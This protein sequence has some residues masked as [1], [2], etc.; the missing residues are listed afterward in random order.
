MFQRRHETGQT[1]AS[2]TERTCDGRW[3]DDDEVEHHL[4]SARRLEQDG[5]TG[6]YRCLGGRVAGY[7]RSR[8]VGDVDEVVNDIF[9]AAFRSLASFEGDASA[10]SKLAVRYRLEQGRRLASLGATPT[11]DRGLGDAAHSTDDALSQLHD[12]MSGPDVAT[13]LATLTDDQ[14]DVLLL[15]IVADLSLAETA[16][17]LGKPAGAIKSLQHRALASLARTL[18]PQPVSPAGSPTNTNQMNEHGLTEAE[19]GRLLGEEF[20]PPVVHAVVLATG[21][22]RREYQTVAPTVRAAARRVR[23]HTT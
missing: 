12:H 23:R 13:L 20:D 9:L 3:L 15:R 21:Q 5:Y 16:A 4:R 19:I 8:G 17:A 22:L 2:T 14:R 7:V 1:W 10:V 6:L 11:R 18:S